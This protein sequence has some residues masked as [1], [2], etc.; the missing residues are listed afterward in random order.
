MSDPI[1]TR[2]LVAEAARNGR[3]FSVLFVKRTDGTERRMTCRMGV[4]RYLKGVGLTFNPWDYHLQVVWDTQK[5]DYR[6]ISLDAVLEIRAR[7]QV[8]VPP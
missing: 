3:I 6:F 4:R 1:A 5:R 7:G 8:I 2:L